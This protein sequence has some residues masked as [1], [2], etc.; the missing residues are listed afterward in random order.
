MSTL[1]RWTQAVLGTPLSRGGRQVRLDR[2]QLAVEKIMPTAVRRIVRAFERIVRA[3]GPPVFVVVNL[4][5]FAA[6]DAHWFPSLAT[7]S[8]ALNSSPTNK[9]KTACGH[10]QSAKSATYSTETK[11]KSLA[12]TARIVTLGYVKRTKEIGLEGLRLCTNG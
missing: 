7:V 5:A 3:D 12:S 6:L 2:A 8:R 11:L 4:T 10:C 1:L 9:R